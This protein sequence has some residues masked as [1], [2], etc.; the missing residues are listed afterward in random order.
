MENYTYS[1]YLKKNGS[2]MKLK[3]TSEFFFH[4]NF[5]LVTLFRGIERFSILIISSSLK[6]C[7]G[8]IASKINGT[9]K[10]VRYFAKSILCTIYLYVMLACAY[11]NFI[12][13]AIGSDQS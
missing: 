12:L 4:G 10:G 5:F 2:S 8:T 7:V 13:L 11:Q 3:A 1:V 6:V 9:P